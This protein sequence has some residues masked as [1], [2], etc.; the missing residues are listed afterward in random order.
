MLASN[1]DQSASFFA[2]F[3]L[4]V[5]Q[6]LGRAEEARSMGRQLSER[7]RDAYREHWMEHILEF[8]AGQRTSHELIAIAGKSQDKRCEAHFYIGMRD[9]S[10]G[11]RTSAREH[12][13]QSA[14]TS[15]FYFFEYN[16]SDAFL[17]RLESDPNWPPWIPAKAES[18][19][20]K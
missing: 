7:F 19:P 6:L 20:P 4:T 16:W 11:D 8:E 1:S 17:K 5:R 13:R 15:F 14:A 2:I 3:G 12:F 9:L 18:S 10:T